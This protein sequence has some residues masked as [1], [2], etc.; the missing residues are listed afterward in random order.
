MAFPQ[1]ANEFGIPKYPTPYSGHVVLVEKIST[2]QGKYLK[3]D[4]LK[5]YI[6]E[7]IDRDKYPFP[8][9][10]VKEITSDDGNYAFRYW[11]NDRTLPEQNQWNYG[12]SFGGEDLTFPYYVRN[13]LVE[14]DKYIPAVKKSKVS[15]VLGIYLTN[16]GTG[17]TSAPTVTLSNTNATAECRIDREGKIEAIYLKSAGTSITGTIAVSFTGGGGSGATAVAVI[18]P[19]DCVLVKEDM[20]PLDSQDPLFSR[21][22]SV[23]QYFETVPGP[24]FYFYSLD[25]DGDLVTTKRRHNFISDFS[26]SEEIDD[27]DIWNLTLAEP[28]D[29]SDFLYWEI[30]TSRSATGS[31]KESVKLDEDG[32]L[33][34]ETKTLKPIE[35]IHPGESIDDGIWTMIFMVPKNGYELLAYEVKVSRE[36]PG[37]PMLEERIDEDGKILTLERQLVEKSAA[38]SEETLDAGIWEKI[39]FSPKSGSSLVVYQITETREVPGNLM[40]STKIEEDSKVLTQTRQ[41]IEKSEAVSNETLASGIWTKRYLQPKS[42]S[43]L[44]GYQ[45]IE[46]RDIPG[47]VL[48]RREIDQETRARI[49][50]EQ[51]LVPATYSVSNAALVYETL[52]PVSDLVSMRITRTLNGG[53]VPSG[54]TEYKL[55]DFEFPKIITGIVFSSISKK[56]G[57]KITK[58][59]LPSRAAYR[60]KISAKIVTEYSSSVLTPTEATTFIP[61]D[62]DYDGVFFSF[63]ERNVLIDGDTINFNTASDDPEWGLVTESLTITASNPSAT[64]YLN[65]ASTSASIIIG[66]QVDYLAAWGIWRKTTISITAE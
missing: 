38:I 51:Q 20:R 8:L 19:A 56:D 34:Y 22:V 10:L 21:Y 44:V 1:P 46:S 2:K 30:I 60:K 63:D 39:Y 66:G 31:S 49:T 47:N 16:K 29:Q 54:R 7:G 6:Y 52:T 50:I 26:P 23:S 65:W 13:F 42:G 43:D 62:I 5:D 45:V 64:T 57:T 53:L 35:D 4:P 3:L 37:N 33:I 32:A 55:I 14:R 25:E 9:Y 28:V 17:Y 27:N 40:T 12:I 48:V 58:A 61:K 24:W 18:Q 59:D 41:L 15:S 36:I 11:C